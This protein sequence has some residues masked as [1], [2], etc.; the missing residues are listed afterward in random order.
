MTTD[1][2]LLVSTSL[3]TQYLALL[4]PVVCIW[5]IKRMIFD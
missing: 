5:F 4:I 3:F 1:I 2:I